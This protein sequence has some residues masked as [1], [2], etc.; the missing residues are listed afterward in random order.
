MIL[1]IEVYY[2][3]FR[4]QVLVAD[5]ERERVR[6]INI[7]HGTTSCKFKYSLHLILFRL[8]FRQRFCLI[9]VCIIIFVISKIFNGSPYSYH[10]ILPIIIKWTNSINKTEGDTWRYA[11][12]WSLYFLFFISKICLHSVRKLKLVNCSLSVL[13][14]ISTLEII[15][16]IECLWY[17]KAIFQLVTLLCD[18]QLSVCKVVFCKHQVNINTNYI[19]YW[20]MV[21]SSDVFI[22]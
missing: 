12:Y 6:F 5:E 16:I 18:I 17:G 7:R 15:W 3:V 4:Q 21:G 10:L 19:S 1:V 11:R 13:L 9:Q 2:Q 14:E 8:Y 22:P 20:T